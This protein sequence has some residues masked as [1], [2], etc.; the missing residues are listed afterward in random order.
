MKEESKKKKR[1]NKICRSG[2]RTWR[3]RVR[4]Y[5]RKEDDSRIH[6]MHFS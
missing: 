4:K 2:R 1:R 5:Q 6:N 3:K